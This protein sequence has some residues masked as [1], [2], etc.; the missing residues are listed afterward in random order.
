MLRRNALI[1]GAVV[2]IPIVVVV[3][4]IRLSGLG[5]DGESSVVVRLASANVDVTRAAGPQSEAAIAVA[6][7]DAR[8]LVAGSN[9]LRGERS[10]CRDRPG[11]A[12]VLRL[13]R[14]PLPR[15]AASTARVHRVAPR[16]DSGMARPPAPGRAPRPARLRRRPPD[17]RRRHRFVQSAHR[18]AL[19]RLDALLVRSVPG[20]PGRGRRQPQRRRWPHLVSAGDPQ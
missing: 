16:A 5:G 11:W 19:R 10:V 15:E 8:T 18:P 13:P 12:A 2:A 14:A 1:I 6:P 20:A 9:D 4:A 7:D 17:H 3:L